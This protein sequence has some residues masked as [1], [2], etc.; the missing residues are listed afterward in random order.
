[1]LRHG[2]FRRPEGGSDSD[3]DPNGGDRLRAPVGEAD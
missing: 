2:A 3:R 1:M